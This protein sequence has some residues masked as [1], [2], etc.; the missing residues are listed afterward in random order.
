M[1]RRKNRV[2]RVAASRSG[3]SRR[4]PKR[5]DC[6]G[7]YVFVELVEPRVFLNGVTV[8]TQGWQ[9]TGGL[10]KDVPDWLITMGQAVLGARESPDTSRSHGSLFVHDIE[11]GG[12][13]PLSEKD[14]ETIWNNS[15]KPS[16]E[17]VLLYNWTWESNDTE[18]GWLEAAADNLFAELNARP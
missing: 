6:L 18:D 9:L 4:S 3:G 1:R 11:H 5:A 7:K 14:G 16:E 17:V 2:N 12:W 15:D 13:E 8:I 10:S